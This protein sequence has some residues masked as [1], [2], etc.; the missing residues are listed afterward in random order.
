MRSAGSIDKGYPFVRGKRG[1]FATREAC[2]GFQGFV[3]HW[4]ALLDGV[5]HFLFG[6]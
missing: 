2:S 4:L 1:F 3:S 5:V 6:C